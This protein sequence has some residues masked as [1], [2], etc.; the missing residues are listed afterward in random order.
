MTAH[1]YDFYP[2]REDAPDE[3]KFAG[4]MLPLFGYDSLSGL[5]SDDLG[6][7]PVLQL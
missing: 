5:P 2:D 4:S 3:D 6:A 1:Y 7:I